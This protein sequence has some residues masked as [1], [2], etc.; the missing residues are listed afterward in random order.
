MTRRSILPREASGAA[1]PAQ[2]LL[3]T[4]T[5]P[6]LPKLECLFAPLEL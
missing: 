3:P 2:E 1:G 5:I 6:M 4:Q